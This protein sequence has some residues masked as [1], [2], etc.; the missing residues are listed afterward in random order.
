VGLDINGSDVV[1]RSSLGSWCCSLVMPLGLVMSGSDV[2]HGLRS[3]S[4]SHS[5]VSQ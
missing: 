4:W 2:V 5:R 1:A 3:V